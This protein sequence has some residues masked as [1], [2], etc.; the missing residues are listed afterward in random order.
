[1]KMIPIAP[2]ELIDAGTAALFR[3]FISSPGDVDAERRVVEEVLPKRPALEN[4][5]AFRAIAWDDPN[6]ST[7][8]PFGLT[9][10]QAIN[11]GLARPSGCD[12]TIVI[13]WGRMGTPL[14]VKD[15]PDSGGPYLSARTGSLRMHGTR[16]RTRFFLC[17]H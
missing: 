12:L 13:L 1:M 2:I 4:R 10:R 14:S 17:P 3:I 8:M 6:R 9:P 16:T 11:R 15:F 5:A 7:P